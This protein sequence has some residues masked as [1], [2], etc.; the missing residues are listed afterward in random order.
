MSREQPASAASGLPPAAVHAFRDAIRGRLIAAG[1]AEYDTARRVFNSSIDRRPALI[2]KCAGASDVVHGVNFARE[3]RLPLA[4]RGG[5]H[6]VSGKAMCDSGLVID[7]SGMKGIRVDPARREADAQAGLTLGDVDRETHAFGLATTLG[8]VSATGIAGLTLGGGIGWLNGQFG[9]ACDNLIAADIVLADGRFVTVSAAEYP[10][11]FWAIRGGGGNFGVV[12][13]FRYRL[14][15][16]HT[17]FGGLVVY[18]FDRARAVLEAFE[19]FAHACPDDV[20]VAAAI[21]TGPDGQPAVAI[22]GCGCG[23]LERNERDLKPL[24]S[25]G[26]PVA[27]LFRPMP[28]TAVQT[29]FDA[30]FQPGFHHYWKSNFVE[31]I[32]GELADVAT[33]FMARKPSPNTTL[34]LQR[35]HGAAARVAPEA[36]A[37][38]HRRV[39]YDCALLSVWSDAAD[40][41]ANIEWTRQFHAALEPHSEQAVY[42]NGLGDEGDA[43]VRAAYGANY[44]R[45]ATIKRIYDPLNLFR[46]NQNIDPSLVAAV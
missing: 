14:H 46:L 15:E 42:V 6:N 7:L 37:F 27:D 36:T 24:R 34:L 18:P 38:P 30:A 1:E 22:A 19:R 45:L 16:V 5:G 31:R 28:Y 3:Q 12:T 9:L 23:P 40:S 2:L 32:T 39:H 21:L 25:I 11:L 43:R 29:M 17:V 33:S 44:A 10:D 35:L 26:E 20:S 13:S 4:I 41:A 8:T